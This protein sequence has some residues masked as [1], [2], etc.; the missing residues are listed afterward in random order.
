[1]VYGVRSTVYKAGQL[2]SRHLRLHRSA[3]AKRNDNTPQTSSTTVT[4]SASTSTSEILAGDTANVDAK[5]WLKS[6]IAL[7][8]RP[9]SSSMTIAKQEEGNE[10]VNLAAGNF[11]TV[12]NKSSRRGK[13][14]CLNPFLLPN[15]AFAQC[16]SS[17]PT[18]QLQQ[19]CRCPLYK[20]KAW[21]RTLPP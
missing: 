14:S 21:H 11:A 9:V 3:R 19:E 5:A 15:P 16:Q 7:P 4:A 18:G 13:S 12:A 8:T 1:M 17:Q 20:L 10:L 6:P 2:H